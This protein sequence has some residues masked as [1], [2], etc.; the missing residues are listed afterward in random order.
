M[1]N[2]AYNF[3]YNR[4]D[5]NLRTKRGVSK[6]LDISTV[7]KQRLELQTIKRKLSNDFALVNTDYSFLTHPNFLKKVLGWDERR[8]KEFIEILGGPVNRNLTSNFIN[9]LK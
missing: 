8:K 7:I 1:E 4:V 2:K 6:N 3:N 9:T 5:K